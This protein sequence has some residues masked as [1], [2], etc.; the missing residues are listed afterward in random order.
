MNKTTFTTFSSIDYKNTDSLSTYCISIAPLLF[1]PDISEEFPHRVVW[2]FGDDTTSKNISALKTY[3]FPGIYNVSLIVYDCDTNAM[4]STFNKEIQVYNFVPFT[5]NIYIDNN[6]YL[7]TEDGSYL[8]TE[9]GSY[10]LINSPDITIKNGQFSNELVVNSYYPYYQPASSI[11]YTINNSNSLN[12]WDIKNNKFSHLQSHHTLYEKMFNFYINEHQFKPIEKLDFSTNELYAKRYNDS[13]VYCDKSDAGAIFVGLSSSKSI[14][15]KDDSIVDTANIQ[16]KFD[17]NNNIVY[18]NDQ[19]LKPDYLNNT[20]ITLQ[21]KIIENDDVEKLS[22]TSS[23]LDGEYYPVSSFQISDI[24]FFDS[25]IPFVVKIKDSAHTSVKNFPIIQLSSLD[26][27]VYANNTVYDNIV[28]NNI[29]LVY[30]GENFSYNSSDNILIDPSEYQIISLNDTLSGYDHNG[31]FRGYIIFPHSDKDLLSNIY[32]RISGI[33]VNDQ[34]IFYNLTAQSNTFN[35][36]NKNYYDIWKINEN[37]NPESTLMDLRF[38]ETLL[39]KNVLFEDFL[40]NALGN[41]DSDHESLGIK[42]YEKTSNFVMNTQDVDSCE[43]DFLDSL[44]KFVGYNDKG[45]ERYQYPERIKRL[46]NLGSVDKFKLTGVTNKFK[47]NF[48]IRGRTSKDEYGINIGDKIDS[49][50]YIVN[51]N[52]PIVALEKFSNTYTLL[53]TYRPSLSTYPLSTYSQDW[54]WPL[55]LPDIFSFSDIEKYYLFFEYVD[56]YDNTPIGGIIDFNN[57]KTTISIDDINHNTFKH[58][59]MD[60]LYQML[61]LIDQ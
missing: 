8:L 55:I 60:V 17:K 36:Y 44:G 25:K 31:S 38:Q 33:F 49:I 14:Y 42:T 43:I 29:P 18:D 52:T 51:S 35:I 1:V 23:G 19:Y 53:N 13:I 2:D 57:S 15:I 61:E 11:F 32:I 40:G 9:D 34:S 59:S 39:D 10:L 6:S 26:I 48:D 5:F 47:E 45:E 56:V 20:G 58:M 4:I 54:G 3:K 21:Y 22:I 7:L 27:S 46:V 16:F 28:Y 41:A 12:Y 24:K 37:F 30:N 50:S